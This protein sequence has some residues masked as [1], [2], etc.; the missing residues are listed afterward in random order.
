MG[1][2]LT[3]PFTTTFSNTPGIL[4]PVSYKGVE[5]LGMYTSFI[6]SGVCAMSIAILSYSNN[7]QFTV[8]V[9]ECIGTDPHT[10]QNSMN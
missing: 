7:I 6:N 8:N 2:N 9:D 1:E 4:K 10:I 5:T 3:L